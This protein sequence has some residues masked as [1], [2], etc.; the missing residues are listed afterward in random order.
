MFKELLK[1]IDA[2]YGR[3][4]R[5][6]FFGKMVEGG[7]GPLFSLPLL[8]AKSA[9]PITAV[10]VESLSG[11]NLKAFTFK[12]R[13]SQPAILTARADFS[14]C[15]NLQELF[16]AFSNISHNVIT[17]GDFRVSPDYYARAF[18][19]STYFLFHGDGFC[20]SLAFLFQ[21]LARKVLNTEVELRYCRTADGGYTHVYGRSGPYFV[22]PALKSFFPM[23]E[24]RNRPPYAWFYTLLKRIGMIAWDNI[25]ASDRAWLFSEATRRNMEFMDSGNF[26]MVY[27][28]D[29]KLQNVFDVFLATVAARSEPISVALDDYSWKRAYREQAIRYGGGKGLFFFSRL[30]RPV[31]IELPPDAVFEV[32]D[33]SNM[34]PLFHTLMKIFYG[35]TFARIRVRADRQGNVSLRLPDL[36]WLIEDITGSLVDL[37]LNSGTAAFNKTGL[38]PGS[39]FI[40]LERIEALVNIVDGP[41]TLNMHTLPG[42][43]IVVHLPLNALFWNSPYLKLGL[44]R[45]GSGLQ[46][47]AVLA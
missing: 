46:A 45:N 12:N 7:Y 39:G 3:S 10:S 14:G 18:S 35:R 38:A 29:A 34:S 2:Y 37:E 4:T 5:Q 23:I 41:L 44:G 40:G 27:R 21:G 42:A 11:S 36:P 19:D 47:K 1:E 28:A 30:E 33:A 25:P 22:D 43:E 32:P 26:Q 13:S 8:E 20:S 31:E 16:A 24:L 17:L 6:E 15:K 9:N